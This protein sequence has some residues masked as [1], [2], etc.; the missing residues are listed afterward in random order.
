MDVQAILNQLREEREQVEEAIL[1]LERF[2]LCQGPRRG[3]P[4]GRLITA[5][6]SKGPKRRGRPPGSR[7]KT[8]ARK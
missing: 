1:A 7:N 5:A 3:R 4:P 8:A 2:Q 6:T